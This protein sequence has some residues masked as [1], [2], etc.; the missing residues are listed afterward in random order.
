M[1]GH[2]TP[3]PRWSF[4]RLLHPLQLR[5]RQ[6]AATVAAAAVEAAAVARLLIYP[7]RSLGSPER[8]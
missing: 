8:R 1:A 6:T 7:K 2:S 3:E 5:G 4:G